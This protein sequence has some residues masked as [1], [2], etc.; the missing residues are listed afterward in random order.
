MKKFIVACCCIFVVAA[1]G[2]CAYFYGGVFVD[3]YSDKPVET[4]TLQYGKTIYFNQ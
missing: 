3:R 2:L 1:L 4:W